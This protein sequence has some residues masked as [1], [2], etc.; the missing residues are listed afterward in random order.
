MG[1]HY[2]MDKSPT[3]EGGAFWVMT[4]PEF[5]AVELVKKGGG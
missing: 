2:N 4:S 1:T 5:L 3:V